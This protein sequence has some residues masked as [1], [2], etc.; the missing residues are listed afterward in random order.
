MVIGEFEK[1]TLISEADLD[2]MDFQ[3]GLCNIQMQK[4]PSIFNGPIVC[5]PS[6]RDAEEYQVGHG[7]V[8]GEGE[9]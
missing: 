9:G 8:S 7:E 3:Q 4:T 2:G 1:R 6:R 5:V